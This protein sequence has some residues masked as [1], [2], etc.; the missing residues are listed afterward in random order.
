MLH[1]KFRVNQVST[2]KKVY[3]TVE[4][5]DESEALGGDHS[6]KSGET[7]ENRLAKNQKVSPKEL[8]TFI[9]GLLKG[10]SEEMS[11]E[12]VKQN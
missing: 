12:L 9:T 3:E 5:D 8:D 1:M 7:E 10:T 2:L 11:V 4:A 6:S